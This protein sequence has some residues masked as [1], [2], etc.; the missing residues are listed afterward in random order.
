[1]SK[2]TF[3]YDQYNNL[4]DTYEHDFGQGAAGGL[5]RRTHT[6]FVS[7][8]PV[9]GADYACN[10]ATTCSNVSITPNVIHI[11]S[12][13]GQQWVS[14]DAAG[15]NKESL[16]AFIYDQSALTDRANITGMCT[17]FPN[18]QCTS[19]NPTSYLTRGNVTSVTR[20]AN[21]AAGTGALTSTST[22]DIAGNV[23][24]ATDPKGFTSQISYTDSFC[25]GS[26]CGGSFTPN[27][28]AF[29][30]GIT[31]PIP[32]V[33]TTFGHPA[34]AFGSTVALTS[35]TVYDFGSGLI[36]STTDPNNKTTTLEY[37][38]VLDRPT[39][40]V[41]A[42]GART[43][44]QYNDVVGN[45]YIRILT[46]LDATRR[47]EARQYFDALGRGVRAFSWENQDA[48]NPW[49]T[50]DTQFDALGRAWRT[51]SQY[52]SAGPGSTVNPSGRWT[53]ATF[54]A[55]SRVTQVK[56][57]ADAATTTTSY[58]GNAVTVTDTTGKSR[59][60]VSD[61]LGRLKEV[62]ED[63]NGLNYLTSYTYDTVGNLRTV[64]QGTQTRTFVYD[65]LSRLTSATNPE[66]GAT[67]YTYDANSNLHTR[68]DARGATATYEHDR[69]N[70]HIITTYSGG[71]T[72]TPE[73]RRHYDWAT[74]GLG[75]LHWTEGLG[76]SATVFDVYDSVGRPT[77]YH[78]SFW[79]GSSYG[80][81][82]NV[83]RSYNKGGGVTS[84]TYPSGR[85]VT[86]NYD[87][88]G[89]LGDFNGQA[90]FGGTLGDGTQRTYASE[91]RYHELGGRQQERFATT[92]PVYNK[93]FYNNR[94]QL[95]EIRV[96]TYSILAP[97]Q[98]TNWNRGAIINHY[99]H[100]SWAGSGTD[101]NG[102]LKKQE[103]YVPD[104][105]Q[106]S[107]HT[108]V[109]QEYNYDSLNRL[110]S[111]YDKPFNGAPDFYQA[112]SY[113][114]WGNRTIDPSTW[115]APEPQFTASTST[116]RLSPPGGYTMTYDAAGNL[117]YDNFTGAG[118]RVY[119]A[120]NRMTSAQDFY[121]QTSVYA[122]DGDGR[123][124]SRTVVGGATVWQV[125]GMGSE[126]LAEYAANGS[127]STP[128]KEY[129][130]RG[131]EL[132][133]QAT[134]P[135]TT[136][137]GLTAQYFDN[138]N[139][140]DLK[141]T[142]TDSTVNFDWGLGSPQ[143]TVGVDTFSVRWEG[144]V[145]P[146]YS[147]TYTFYTVTDDGVRLWVNNQ[148]IIDKWIDQGPTEWSGQIALTAGQ[149]Y[150][151]RMEF[152]ENGGGATAK[153]LWSSASQ[154]KV[155]IA[156]SRLYPAG[157]GNA[158]VD[159]QWLVSDQLGTPRMVIDQTGS[160]S[161]VKRH[162]YLPFGEE[163]PSDA[164]WRTIARGYVGDNV[165][166]EFTKYERDHETGLDYAQ[167]RY[168][169]SAQGRFTGV[170]PLLASALAGAPQ[171]WN[172][173]SYALNNPLRLIDPS[174]MKVEE[175]DEEGSQQAQP[176]TSPPQQV[177]PTTPPSSL[178]YQT[179]PPEILV[180]VPVPG[181]YFTGVASIN[182]IAVTNAQ[183]EVIKSG[184][185]LK[186][187]VLAD[188]PQEQR[189]VAQNA[190]EMAPYSNGTFVDIVGQG[191]ITEKPFDLNNKE[192][193]QKATDIIGTALAKPVSES[194]TQ[195][196]E[197]SVP[198][199]GVVLTATTQHT[200]SNVDPQN[201]GQVKSYRNAQGGLIPNYSVTVQRVSGPI[202][203][204]NPRRN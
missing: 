3:S 28:Y 77:Q 32:D 124:V 92:T 140:T 20:Y 193:V 181:G 11:R 201:P 123:R 180:N 109:V 64:T 159:L 46:D 7:I 114:R 202:K 76:V 63:P 189:D 56:T 9:N 91:V 86:Y 98:E 40:Q 188:E 177:T 89:R 204:T 17:T 183:G 101:N 43:D 83:L 59:K 55:L 54:D 121:G 163:I 57:T 175:T 14:S 116:N 195:K 115:G 95:S 173:Y 73:A 129:G 143:A 155:A 37:N 198:G 16:T 133:V 82:F 107:S 85:T 156:Q 182:L 186:E 184:V 5:V 78:Q 33:S 50:S 96:S 157:S 150:D 4:T 135:V 29:A 49:L 144:K 132:L 34:G 118:T 35:S 88:A 194:V 26:T 97:G 158:Q 48:V 142:R 154:A 187:T 141:L 160:L 128:Q 161:G 112:Y 167:A 165:R 170:D 108:N 99:S 23:V 120:E 79:T 200:V 113:D 62:Y 176:K 30:T 25:N 127:P 80:Q 15:S 151:I 22:Y 70:R 191:N 162:D 84:Q 196:L 21:A 103:I 12:L 169:A 126:L 197:V 87:A 117:T 146:L 166:Q 75:R 185:T 147:Q 94:A 174:G 45:L 71:G 137:T 51:S 203:V 69:L 44:I 67:S 102:N 192:D 68:T 149:R 38:D 18:G 125:Y 171:T 36:Y 74:N 1:M 66:S 93:S 39:A 111:V 60:S 8:N 179:S 58:T 110:T 119:D 42:D 145:E 65:S 47:T 100:Q 130:Y 31:S 139:F 53:E 90:A 19:V 172:R 106:I 81:A 199:R 2:Q 61:G 134:A 131:G 72:T 6:D 178:I 10:P 41:R 136:G 105:D 13:P 190:R 168:F 24:S 27:T 138:M 104:N 152:Y 153:L 122:Y 52:R 148:L 164:T